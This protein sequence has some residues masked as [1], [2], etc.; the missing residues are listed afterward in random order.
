MLALLAE[1]ALRSILLGA[2]AWF[3]LT[4]M[5]VRNPQLRMTAWSV[6]LIV[7]MA[8]PALTPWMRVTIPAHAASA[9]LVKLAWADVPWIA[10]PAQRPAAR[11][12]AAASGTDAVAPAPAPAWDWRWLA[13]SMYVC[14]GSAMLLRLLIG[15]VLMRHV[16]RAARPA[17][18]DW[19]AGADVRLSDIVSVPVTF[20][21]TIVLPAASAEWSACKRQAVLLHEGSH[22]AD[23]DFYLLLL[24]SINRAVF[25][26]NPFAWWLFGYLADLAE[27]VSDDAAVKGIG[28]RASYADILLDIA[29]TPQRLPAGLAMAHPRTVQRRVQRILTATAVP[30]ASMSRR[31]RMLVAAAL[32]PLAALS[33]VTIAQ[34]AA[35]VQADL[36]TPALRP[37]ASMPTVLGASELDRYV[38]QFQMTATTVL[39]VLR[40][41]DQLFTQATGQP[42]LRLI[43]VREHEF[44]K[45][46]VNVHVTFETGDDGLATAVV[47]HGPNAESRRGVRIDAAEASAIDAAFQRRIATVADRFRDQVPLPGAKD[48]L[49]RTIDDLRRSEPSYARMSPQLADKLHRQRPELQSMLSALGALESLF[50]R[51]VSPFGLD[52]YGGKF[53]G[54]LAELRIDLAADGSIADVKFRLDGDGTRG[55]VEACAREPTLHAAPTAAP[56]TLS[57][58]NR[59]G[60]NQQLFWLDQTGRR[61]SQGTLAN[62]AS[63]DMQ[64]SVLRPLVISDMTGQCREIVLPGQLT[65]VHVLQE[66]APPP[67]LSAVL[68]AAPIPGSDE[69]L[70]RHIER[71]SRGTPDYASMTSEAATVTR[72]QLPQQQAILDTLGAVQSMLFRGVSPGGGD[73]YMVRFANGSAIWQ[74]ALVDDGRIAAVTLSP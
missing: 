15:L 72:Q 62:A 14:V 9:R 48:A 56:I 44:V 28:D 39:T 57:L 52:I 67:V 66:G 61:Q 26:F 17:R 54:G 49:R 34:S 4:V 29:L 2:A 11:P 68:R 41:G 43:P 60:A 71:L 30:A 53:A 12:A 59:S 55:G 42:R 35:P 8:M 18:E 36:T 22:V 40:Q 37:G 70:Q 6:V 47:V 58:T 45:E 13:T 51:G 21:S 65:R 19:T 25:W 23:G 3:G 69:A 73:I 64:T 7:S 32:G 16:V 24:A 5:R 27:L 33:A 1:T 10:S 38:G 46:L 50:F 31:R 74:I 63:I 20:A